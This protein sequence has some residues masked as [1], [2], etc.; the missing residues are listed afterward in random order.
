MAEQESERQATSSTRSH[1]S[2][3]SKR[4]K[5]SKTRPISSFS[6]SDSDS[7]SDSKT[8]E[9]FSNV[10]SSDSEDEEDF[11]PSSEEDQVS[12][13]FLKRSKPPNDEEYERKKKVPRLL[14]SPMYDVF[15]KNLLCDLPITRIS[16]KKHKTKISSVSNGWRHLATYHPELNLELQ[17]LSGSSAIPAV[18]EYRQRYSKKP[19][20][21][22]SYGFTSTADRHEIPSGVM[23]RLSQA[24]M[25][26]V[27][28]FPFNC[29]NEYFR[30][31]LE[32]SGAN[33]RISVTPWSI[34]NIYLPALAK[35]ID[36]RLFEELSQI[37]GI[38]I[39]Y[40][41]W[42]DVSQKK[43][44]IVSG[45]YISRDFL[46]RRIALAI[47]DCPYSITILAVREIV[48]SI[49]QGRIGHRVPI[50]SITTDGAP[51]MLNSASSINEESGWCIP[52]RLHLVVLAA[53]EEDP[54]AKSLI[55]K[56]RQYSKSVR[57]SS[58]RT[59]ALLQ[60]QVE[61]KK[62]KLLLD[63]PL[64]WSSIYQMLERFRNNSWITAS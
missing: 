2:S 59:E 38:S 29:A 35:V 6:D 25:F 27:N 34:A 62:L 26:V 10:E 5:R 1:Q 40:D 61:G 31:Q 18:G 23:A 12:G 7:D 43:Y 58:K 64:R 54:E 55:S 28:H 13:S 42:T 60:A 20:S 50:A 11:I 51:N 45:H 14:R 53:V 47:H 41:V 3:R 56:V 15:G 33:P 49:I 39:T 63:N 52:H 16:Q 21:I 8:S 44:L 4:S 32:Y 36:Q 9:K 24:F 46:S 19:N 22:L 17:K 48:T 30:L 37:K 57:V